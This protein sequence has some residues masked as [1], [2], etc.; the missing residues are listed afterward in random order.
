M[1][2]RK[3]KD[4]VTLSVVGCGGV[5]LMGY[6]QK[7]ADGIVSEC[8]DHGINYFD[9]APSYGD[10]EAEIL[11]GPALEAYRKRSFLACKTNKRSAEEG[12][13]E[14]RQ[15]LERLRTDYFDLYQLHGIFHTD[16]DV[17]AAFKKGGVMDFLIE[18]KKEEQIRYLG[19]STHSTEAAVRAMDRYDFDSILFP[20]NYACFLKNGFGKEIFTAAAAKNAACLA[21]KAMARQEWQPGDERRDS[22]KCWYEPLEDP[23]LLRLAVRWTLS[24]P[25]TAI[26]PSGEL[27][28]FRHALEVATEETIESLSEEE[29]AELTADLGNL[30]PIFPR[31]T[32]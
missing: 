27:F 28:Q 16:A 22:S 11:M 30:Q 3:Y 2:Y 14:F 24:Q 25:V 5:L 23:R 19:F 7:D 21:L 20:V 29:F 32:P 1:E 9:V 12:A 8:A 31:A 18:R 26:V 4:D 13:F 6:D 15:S 17:D 10:G